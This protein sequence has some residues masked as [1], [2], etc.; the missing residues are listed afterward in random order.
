MPTGFPGIPTS[1]RNL[2]P[3]DISNL[4]QNWKTNKT[5]GQTKAL[6]TPES[7]PENFQV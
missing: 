1:T 5:L 6:L 4:G 2:I 3:M 7:L